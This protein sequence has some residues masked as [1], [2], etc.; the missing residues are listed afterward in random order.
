[1]TAK[2]R[3]PRFGMV[4]R[5][6][7]LVGA[8]ASMPATP[9]PVA[10]Q[11]LWERSDGPFYTRLILWK[12][13]DLTEEKLRL[14]Y[15]ELSQELKDYSAWTVEV[16]LDQEDATRESHGKLKTEGDYD[17][18]LQ[19]Y[20][21][22]GRNP[23]PMAEISTYRENGV[24]RL[25]DRRGN[26]KEIVFAGKNFLRARIQGT[27]FEI[28]KTYYHP[29]PPQTESSPGDEAMISIYVRSLSS[30]SIELAGKFSRLMQARFQQKR[31]M[32]AF[33]TDAYFLTDGGFPIVYRF[34]R[35]GTPPSREAYGRSRTIY[36]FCDIPGIQCR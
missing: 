21:E 32:V 13:S 23:L 27:D 9:A 29:L 14:L 5:L 31:I 3:H 2:T 24:L 22:F 8:A 6:L 15:V 12:G 10:G 26:S 34:D 33:R 28:L 16:F 4:V 30:P 1:M 25:R 36:C 11:T 18:W 7:C 20:N 35:P 19:L 17:W